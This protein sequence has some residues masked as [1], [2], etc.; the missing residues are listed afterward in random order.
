MKIRFNGRL[1]AIEWIANYA[2]NEGQFEVLREQLNFNHIY[3]GFY[4]LKIEEEMG[5]VVSLDKNPRES[6]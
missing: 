2:E 5:E 6:R 4:F 1:E 3:E